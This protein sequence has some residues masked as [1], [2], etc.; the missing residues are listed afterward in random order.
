M[1]GGGTSNV[2]SADNRGEVDVARLDNLTSA[3][4]ARLRS[5]GRIINEAQKRVRAEKVDPDLLKALGM[6][7][8]EFG[9]FV[10][11]YARRF[12]KTK[13]MPSETA[14]PTATVSGA[15]QLTGKSGRQSGKGVD[16]KIGSSGTEKLSP[17]ELRKLYESR[18]AKV[19]PRFRKEV[20]AYFRAISEQSPRGATTAPAK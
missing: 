15:F 13:K 19:S 12:G 20:E 17:D 11:K 3:E 7:Q 5:L 6:T 18:A 14:R 8:A 1:A 2:G 9:A 4:K 10:E 16:K